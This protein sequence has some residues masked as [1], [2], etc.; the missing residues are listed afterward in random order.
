M[1]GP[2]PGMD[3]WLED[4]CIWQ[5]VHNAFI[6][7]AAE[8]LQALI[9]PRFVAAVEA[10]VY[11]ATVGRNIVPDV[12]LRHGPRGRVPGAAPALL[13]PDEALV[14]EHVDDE[15][16]EAYIEI[17]DLETNQEVVTVIEVLSPSNKIRGEGQDLY[18]TKQQEVLCSNVSLVEIDLLRSGP[19]VLGV[20]ESEVVPIG[21]YDYL[22]AISRSWDRAKR[23][24]IYARTIR[25]RLPRI[26]IP[27]RSTDPAPTLDLQVLLE[28][29]YDAGAFDDRLD[30]SKP[31]IPRLR[32][33][34]EG[35]AQERITDWQAARHV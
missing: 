28:R 35:W 22:V 10:R 4:A 27:L 17:L 24:F 21:V 14:L 1:S 29:V 20:P 15:I 25:E 7:Y 30:Y 18:L 11:I 26:P 13:E 8:A 16:E 9:R 23:S 33:D 5:G 6:V 2:F 31:C 34:D 32:P 12:I 19:H 3:P